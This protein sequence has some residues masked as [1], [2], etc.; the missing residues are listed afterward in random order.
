MKKT[1]KKLCIWILAVNVFF[2][3]ILPIA[4]YQNYNSTPMSPAEAKNYLEKSD[5][6]ILLT[7][8]EPWYY[9]FR[10]FAVSE[11]GKV[12]LVKAR[13]NRQLVYVYNA[14][15]TFL[16]GYSLVDSNQAIFFEDG[17][18]SIYWAKSDC[19]ETMD[20]QGNTILLHNF[21]PSAHN[22]ASFERDRNPPASGTAGEYS[23]R[24]EKDFFFSTTYSRF[25]LE[26]AQGNEYVIYDVS[27][28]KWERLIGSAVAILLLGGTVGLLFYAK[29]KY[30]RENEEKA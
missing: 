10:T 1:I 25:V 11:D 19:I 15:G 7:E 24:A 27:G 9:P 13:Q 18:L 30:D 12:A 3:V 28:G 8:D 5:P 29:K 17:E 2:A 26:D 22:T 20:S 21:T 6:N 23:Y 4:A 14:E 16:Y